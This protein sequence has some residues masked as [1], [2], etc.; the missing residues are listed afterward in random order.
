MHKHESGIL[1]ILTVLALGALAARPMLGPSLP[2]S[3]DVGFH[4][5][6]AAQLD[7]L[8]RQGIL[9]SRWA[10]DMGLGYGYPLFNYLPQLPYYVVVLLGRLGGGLNVGVRLTFALSLWASGLAMYRFA[11]EHFS[12]VAALVA[13]VAYMYAPY[14]AYDAL[15]RGNLSESFAWPLLPLA[16]WG[17]GRLARHGGRKWVLLTALSYAAILL[18]HNI[19]AMITTPLLGLYVLVEAMEGRVFRVGRDYIRR[20]V[21]PLGALALGM[22]LAAFSWVPAIL[23][24]SVVQLDRLAFGFPFS[25]WNHFLSAG[26][27]FL[28]YCPVFLDLMNPSPPRTLGLLAVLCGL[29]GV[30]GVMW[31]KT[32]RQRR[33]VAFFG[34]A[35]AGYAF[36]MTALSRPV[37]DT[38]P[39]LQ[40]TEFPWRLLSPA[41]LCLALLAAGATD[42]IP[43]G[44]AQTVWG[45]LAISALI[46]GDLFWLTPRYCA[47]PLHPGAAD[48]RAQELAGL[49]GTT[50]AGEFLPVTVKALPATP[51]DTFLDRESLPEGTDVFTETTTPLTGEVW[52]DLPQAAH[53]VFNRFAYPGWQ[54]RVDGISQ[55][56]FPTTP[57]GL[58][59]LPVPAGAH[60]VEIAFGTTPL[61][62]AATLVSLLSA[63]ALVLVE[64]F[65]RR[66]RTEAPVA[67][68]EALSARWLLFP[69]ALVLLKTGL[70][71]AVESPL[72]VHRLQGGGL[73]GV[74]VSTDLVF[75]H[76][77]RLLGYE[78]FA[79]TT[80]ADAPL[81][82]TLYVQDVVP[83]GPDYV[84]YPELLD[85]AGEVWID[86][87]YAPTVYKPPPSQTSN[88]P[89]DQVAVLLFDLWP[90]IGTPPG[91]YTLALKVF[92]AR[93]QFTYTAYAGDQAVGPRVILGEIE[94]TH[95]RT[96]FNVET[97]AP[98]AERMSALLGPVRLVWASIGAS[99][100]HP[101]DP[102]KL[103]LAWETAASPQAD[104]RAQLT[105]EAANGASFP[106]ATLP[107]VHEDFPTT[108]WQVGDV[109]RG[110]HTLRLPA[111]LE[112]GSYRLDL[113]L[114]A[115]SGASCASMESTAAIGSLS[116]TAPE[117][118]WT[119]PPLDVSL[120]TRLGASVT[121]VGVQLT[122]YQMP[123][124]A[125]EP[126]TVTLV[127]RDEAELDTA[128]RVFV[129]LQDDSGYPVT[130]SD[131]EPVQWSRPT[132]GWLPGEIVLDERTLSLPPD[133]APGRY[134][135]VAGLYAPE[136][137][138]LLTADGR[139]AVLI[140]ELWVA[141]P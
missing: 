18:T 70:L 128:L 132:T 17:L 35:L 110:Q 114:C 79:V 138:R 72:S 92:D 13:A 25:Y 98:E 4:L 65:G 126:F 74:G 78:P 45:V 75:D 101:G 87:P 122:P 51:A 7:L 95:P 77:L 8:L 134:R 105:L 119:V 15:F 49:I 62:V 6:R 32:G 24:R 140:T 30:L 125:G 19:F 64:R 135:L 47:N 33:Q 89:P 131:G 59:S 113:R 48:I 29:P 1:A 82:L 121:L 80:R 57:E 41:A 86:F 129:H 73:Q 68:S 67:A 85:A 66:S 55:P 136:G 104:L 130:Q 99:E 108:Q 117:R 31:L 94:I 54:A 3:D 111:R 97:L 137:P 83:G 103:Q 40:L 20:L 50:S 71:D 109:W 9:Y 16:L 14:Q 91:R 5:L 44:K 27:L 90:K 22:G 11:R 26:E 52:L 36:L 127:W 60:L 96:P 42:L 120:D 28:S 38:F 53:L 61:R 100:A 21:P 88:W 43:R 112:T 124:H 2:C 123:L 81:A 102:L 58:I 63:L 37:W 107:L 141:E 76:Q 84:I 39:L 106:L 56:T 93:S 23:E 10:P 139:D 46:V 69:V 116:L 34:A 12:A 115:L 118:L 133:L